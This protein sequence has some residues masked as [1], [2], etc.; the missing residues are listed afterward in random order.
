GLGLLR[1]RAR[2]AGGRLD[3]RSAPGEGTVLT[4]RLPRPTSPLPSAVVPQQPAVVPSLAGAV[5]G[6]A[7]R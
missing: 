5:S 1:E 7:G 6:G 3:V 2:L 4:L